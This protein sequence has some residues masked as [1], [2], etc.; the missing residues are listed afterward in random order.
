M[1]RFCLFWR[2]YRPALRKRQAEAIAEALQPLL[3]LGS[4]LTPSGDDLRQRI[5]AGLEA[6]GSQLAP[7]LPVEALSQAILPNAYCKTTLLSANLIECAA[8][9]QADERLLLALDAF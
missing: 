6:V 4:G 1:A 3:G 7:E 2:V 8:R 5:A 9:G